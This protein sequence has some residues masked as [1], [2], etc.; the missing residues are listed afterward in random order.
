MQNQPRGTT[1]H[2]DGLGDRNMAAEARKMALRS[3]HETCLPD[4]KSQD[5][6]LQLA[7]TAGESR[8]K[9]AFLGWP[10]SSVLVCSRHAGPQKD[11]SDGQRTA[12]DA[13]HGLTSDVQ[14]LELRVRQRVC[15]LPTPCVKERARWH[16]S[17]LS[18]CAVRN[19]SLHALASS[20]KRTDSLEHQPAAACSNARPLCHPSNWATDT[21]GCTAI[22]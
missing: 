17:R 18:L 19:K 9:T 16:A 2:R 11:G 7:A 15:P 6:N 4:E 22:I 20:L 13:L 12:S 21:P 8:E 3:Q 14:A 1:R 5:Q 10:F